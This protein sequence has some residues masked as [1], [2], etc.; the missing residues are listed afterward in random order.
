MCKQYH[1]VLIENGNVST[2]SLTPGIKQALCPVSLCPQF[3]V[4]TL[5]VEAA[6]VVG[7]GYGI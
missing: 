2:P 3:Y 4:S 7:W 6:K 1:K 5:R